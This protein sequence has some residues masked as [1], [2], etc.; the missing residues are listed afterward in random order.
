MTGQAHLLGSTLI[1]AYY[2]VNTNFTVGAPFAIGSMIG[3]IFPDVD[4]KH[5]KISNNIPLISF[6]AR[7]FVG[8]RGIIHTPIF[9]II[10]C[11]VIKCICIVLH[12][13]KHFLNGFICGFICHLLQ[14]SMTRRGI[15]WL[16]P[17]INKSFRILHLRSGRGMFSGFFEVILTVLIVGII[18]FPIMLL[19]GFNV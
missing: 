7:L 14:D 17:F 4:E 11:F 18:M 2:M 6:I 16:Y 12:I 19:G 8:H 1:G 3:G 15:K 10:L 9:L 5:S 13:P